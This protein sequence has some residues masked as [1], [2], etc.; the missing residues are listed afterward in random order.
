MLLYFGAR[1]ALHG[2]R[3]TAALVVVMW[4]TISLVLP[5]ATGNVQ[6]PEFTAQTVDLPVDFSGDLSGGD[7]SGGDFSPSDDF[8]GELPSD[9]NIITTTEEA[10]NTN[11]NTGSIFDP[12]VVTEEA[13]TDATPEVVVTEMIEATEVTE[14][15]SEGGN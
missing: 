2:R 7:F 9:F 5:A 4:I 12:V 3:W 8:S 1:F 14:A 10:P 13:S 15:T 6:V 11:D